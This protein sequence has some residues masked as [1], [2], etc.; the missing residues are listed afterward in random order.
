[1]N[2]TPIE[3]AIPVQTRSFLGSATRLRRVALQ[4]VLVVL[5]SFNCRAGTSPATHSPTA[6]DAV[7]LHTSPGIDGIDCITTYE[8]EEEPLQICEDSSD[9]PNDLDEIANPSADRAV[10]PSRNDHSFSSFRLHPSSFPLTPRLSACHSLS[11]TDFFHLPSYLLLSSAE[12]AP[13]SLV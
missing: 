2:R 8:A 1:V 5:A 12:R 13:P 4:I 6:T 9:L 10:I 7:A 11:S 3:T